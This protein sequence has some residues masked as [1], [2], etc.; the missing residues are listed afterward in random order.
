M[1]S[2]KVLGNDLEKSVAFWEDHD[3][4][5]QTRRLGFL[6]GA[7]QWNLKAMI[8]RRASI[9]E[10]IVQWHGYVVIELFEMN[11]DNIDGTNEGLNEFDDDS[12]GPFL[13]GNFGL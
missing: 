1:K 2:I 6:S 9:R 5:S 4:A 12:Y 7:S 8:M 11:E 10:V 13:T 3:V